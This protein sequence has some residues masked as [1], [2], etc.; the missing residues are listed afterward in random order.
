[1]KGEVFTPQ[2]P[3]DGEESMPVRVR[4]FAVLR[5]C[6]GR[7]TIDLRLPLGA[8]AAEAFEELARQ[9]ALGELL[10]R[11][12][13]RLAVNR[14]I[15]AA[16]T[17]LDA[18]DE[19]ALIPPVSGGAPPHARLTEAPLSVE[20]V[21]RRVR[22][23]GAGA[24]VVFEG[25]TRE[26]ERLEYEAYREMA[27]ERIATILA[28]CLKRHDLLGAAAEHRV[29]AVP[30]GEPAV[31]VAVSAAHR[32]EAFAAASE[33]IEAIKAEAPV[34]KREVKGGEARWMEGVPPTAREL[35]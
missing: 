34:W 5:E 21:A 4:L 12:P 2:A 19:L 35:R 22:D 1:M 6:A 8:T 16:T 17:P 7:E 23:P 9:P 30:L 20:A 31:V 28:D 27:E 32:A 29:G 26:V 13:V 25:V 3:K 24:I 33:A 14:E 18:G 10:E 11:M 15:V